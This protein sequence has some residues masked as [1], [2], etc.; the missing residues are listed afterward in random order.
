MVVCSSG[1]EGPGG[2]DGEMLQLE[3]VYAGVESFLSFFLLI[4]A[5]VLILLFGRFK[6]K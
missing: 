4:N 1:V 5:I 3:G 6:M 2:N